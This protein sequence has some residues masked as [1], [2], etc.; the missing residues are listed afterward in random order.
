ME[1]NNRKQFTVYHTT[2]GYIYDWILR[3]VLFLSIHFIMS[4]QRVKPI[5]NDL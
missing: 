5:F 4:H 3:K 2:K 1:M